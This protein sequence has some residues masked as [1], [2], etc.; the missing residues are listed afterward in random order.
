LDGIDWTGDGLIGITD[1]NIGLIGVTGIIG[2]TGA[3]AEYLPYDSV[4]V[5]IVI[6]GLTGAGA[7]YLPYDS[8]VVVVVVGKVAVIIGLTGAC[9]EYP[10]YDSV[11]VSK[12][13]VIIGLTGAEYP[14]YPDICGLSK[15]DII[16]ICGLT[17][18]TSG[19]LHVIVEVSQKRP[20][21]HDLLNANPSIPQTKYIEVLR[22][23]GKYWNGV[24]HGFE[25]PEEHD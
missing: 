13:G 8:V 21:A 3:G 18:L 22:L 11:V 20:S 14:P 17:C 24:V 5:G 1:E 15:I 10:P 9:A 23:F 25:T 12:V 7:E 2:V 16:G 6:I 4:V 19:A